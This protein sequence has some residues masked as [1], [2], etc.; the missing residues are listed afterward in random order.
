MSLRSI[1]SSETERFEQLPG[2]GNRLPAS[3]FVHEREYLDLIPWFA[4]I[5]LWEIGLGN[6]QAGRQRSSVGVGSRRMRNLN[7]I[8]TEKYR[9]ADGGAGLMGALYLRA[10]Q[11][12]FRAT[13]RNRRRVFRSRWV[14]VGRL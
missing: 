10:R 9:G 5:S 7:G 13:D 12:S 6:W 3:K 2:G 4:C 11:G 14:N 8:E 1:L